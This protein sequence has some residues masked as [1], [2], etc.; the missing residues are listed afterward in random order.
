MA[1]HIYIVPGESG[2]RVWR[3]PTMRLET[4]AVVCLPLASGLTEDGGEGCIGLEEPMAVFPGILLAI[5]SKWA[6]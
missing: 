6:V 2:L 4:K 5:L 3:T 1:Q